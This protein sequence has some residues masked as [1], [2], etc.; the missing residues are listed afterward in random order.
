MMLQIFSGL[1][2][3]NKLTQL[4]TQSL[5]Q[6]ITI[7]HV[8]LISIF[9]FTFPSIY[10]QRSFHKE[11]KKLNSFDSIEEILSNSKDENYFP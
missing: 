9:I 4:S 1:C 6:T 11:E 2:N 5:S 7:N 3:E 8:W 10:F